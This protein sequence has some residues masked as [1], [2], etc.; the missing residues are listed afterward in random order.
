[1]SRLQTDAP[2]LAPI[3]GGQAA[4]CRA[5]VSALRTLKIENGGLAALALALE[6]GMAD[7]FSKAV[8]I[9][10]AAAG[11]VIV[12]GMGKSGH[13]GQKIAATFSSTGT[14]AY[15]VHPSEASHGDLGMI[16]RHDVVLALS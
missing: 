4:A 1:M 13:V 15:F 7:A 12:T 5:V 10:A 2:G 16:T 6:T 14:P 3:A 11:R 8:S 9:M